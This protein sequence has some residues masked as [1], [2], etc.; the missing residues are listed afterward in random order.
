LH[1]DPG[2]AIF[3]STGEEASIGTTV[4]GE[5]NI[6]MAFK[7]TTIKGFGG[8]NTDERGVGG[9]SEEVGGLT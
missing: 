8:I 5:N 3:A 1:P 4:E 2:R 9:E 7:E 6:T